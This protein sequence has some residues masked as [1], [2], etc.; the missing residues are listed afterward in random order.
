MC[1]QKKCL[2][3]FEPLYRKRFGK[4][5][6]DLGIF[7]KR[8]FCSM[9]CFREMSVKNATSI[10]SA[11]K[12][13]QMQLKDRCEECGT[14]NKLTI[15][16]IDRNPLNNTP[17]NLKTLC[18]SCHT[19]L[20]WKEDKK[21]KPKKYIGNCEVCGKYGLLKRKMCQMHFQRF[22]KYGDPLKKKVKV[23]R[24]SFKVVRVAA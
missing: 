2:N 15:H 9:Y 11:R 3:C 22:K 19:K 17:R 10:S 20:H 7:L 4:R 16:H 8:K 21:A 23:G 24:F 6:E 13:A 18:A 14:I 5:L 12:R 1:R